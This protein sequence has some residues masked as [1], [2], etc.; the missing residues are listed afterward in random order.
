MKGG[1][2]AALAVASV[3]LVLSALALVH[4]E[5]PCPT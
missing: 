5:K 2:A 4:Q 3:M 1:V